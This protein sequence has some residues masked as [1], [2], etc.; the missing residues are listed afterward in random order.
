MH[1]DTLGPCAAE[2]HKKSYIAVHAGLAGIEGS[3][4]A[5]QSLGTTQERAK[6]SGPGALF[7]AGRG[8]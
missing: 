3:M 5:S 6:V 4:T 1:S 7:Q 2:A 8:I